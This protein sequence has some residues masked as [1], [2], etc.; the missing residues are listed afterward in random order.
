MLQVV[1]VGETALYVEDLERSS[2]FYLEVFGFRR[3]SGDSRFV[4]LRVAPQQV[5]LLFKKGGSREPVKTPGGNI[6]PHDAEGHLH[7]AFTIS[8]SDWAE[9]EAL[10]GTRS[11]EIESFVDWG[12]GKRSLYFRDPDGHLVELATPGL[13][14]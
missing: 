6:P 12:V 8:P 1:G 5:L 11:V 7:L 2:R 14:D 3:I 10:L 13:W 4:A 9:W